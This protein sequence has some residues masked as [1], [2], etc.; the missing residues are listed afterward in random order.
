MKKV[1]SN[2]TDAAAET[3]RRMTLTDGPQRRRALAVIWLM[4]ILFWCNIADGGCERDRESRPAH[5][6]V[7]GQIG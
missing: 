3:N 2:R 7:G 5:A 1:M 6:H 4:S